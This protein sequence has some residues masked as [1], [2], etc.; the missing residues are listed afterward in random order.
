MLRSALGYSMR[1][2]QGASLVNGNN[3]SS[4]S[5][6]FGRHYIVSMYSNDLECLL[7]IPQKQKHALEICRDPTGALR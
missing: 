2:V 3:G 7:Q 4:V 6:W 1:E 5:L